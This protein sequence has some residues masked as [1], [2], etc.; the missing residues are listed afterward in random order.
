MYYFLSI[1]TNLGD[2]KANII[3]ALRFLHDHGNIARCSAVYQTTPVDMPVKT[4][5]FYNL[6]LAY[7]STESPIKLLDL[8]KEFERKCGRLPQSECYESRI[9]D[10]DILFADTIVVNAIHLTIPHKLLH[11]RKFLLIPMNEIAPDL[12]HPIFNKS[13][14]T[15]LSELNSDENVTKIFELTLKNRKKSELPG[16]MLDNDR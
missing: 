6:T 5:D 3:N 16:K 12:R 7:N 14:K 11:T 15:L 8:I 10:I 13:I 2:K 1:G 9:I 4:P